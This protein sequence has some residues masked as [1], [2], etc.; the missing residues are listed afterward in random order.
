[1]IDRHRV[2]QNI[3]VHTRGACYVCTG[4]VGVKREGP[5]VPVDLLSVGVF[6][7]ALVLVL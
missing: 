1:M 7:L 2:L 4:Q 5:G 3:M 6:V